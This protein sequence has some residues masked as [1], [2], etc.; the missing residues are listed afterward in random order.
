MEILIEIRDF[1]PEVVYLFNLMGIGGLA[2]ID[3]LN[4]I[5]ISWVWHLMDNIPA[6]FLQN[7]SKDIL[8]IFDANEGKIYKS[9]QFISMSKEWVQEIEKMGEFS[10]TVASNE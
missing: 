2:I 9:G 3:I 7:I 10:T 4:I 5:K 6:Q 1:K 8:E